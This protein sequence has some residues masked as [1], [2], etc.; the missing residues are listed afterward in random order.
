MAKLAS[1]KY[2][3]V[4]QRIK[5]KLDRRLRPIINAT[6]IAQQGF[7]LAQVKSWIAS[8]FDDAAINTML[9]RG[10]AGESQA[11]MDALLQ[12]EKQLNVI[13][14]EE[15]NEMYY[16][17]QGFADDTLL[18]WVGEEDERTCPD[19]GPRIGQIKTLS[20]WQSIGTPQSGW[21]VCG[22]HCRCDL[23]KP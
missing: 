15:A 22:E 7:M 12:F 3:V 8:G 18:E 21:S 2:G 1:A 23:V 4:E 10:L 14:S 13:C 5:A 17:E 9:E 16:A 20:E 11:F 19:C 6:V